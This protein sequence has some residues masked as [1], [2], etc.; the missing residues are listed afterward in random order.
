LRNLLTSIFVTLKI[1]IF[2]L[3]GVS[4]LKTKIYSFVVNDQEL[5]L[6]EQFVVEN[7]PPFGKEVANLDDRLRIIGNDTGIMS[8]YFKTGL[9]KP[10]QHICQFYDEPKS[11]LRLFFIEE[12][13]KNAIFVGGGGLKPT[14]ARA[15]Q[16][17]PTL[18]RHRELLIKIEDILRIAEDN[19]TLTIQE[20]GSIISKTD[21]IYYSK[22]HHDEKSA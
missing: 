5:M 14:N 7:D 8:Q 19:G 16:D 10:G 17:D 2:E 12:A 20:D 22:D 9:G 1:E 15:T 6:Y 21:Y 11:K 18:N 3:E 13:R 4:G